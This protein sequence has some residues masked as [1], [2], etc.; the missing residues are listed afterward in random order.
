MCHHL[1]HLAERRELPCLGFSLALEGFHP[2]FGS[3]DYL[4]HPKSSSQ[5]HNAWVLDQLHHPRSVED[6]LHHPRSV[7]HVHHHRARQPLRQSDKRKRNCSCQCSYHDQ[8]N[9]F[10][11]RN[12]QHNDINYYHPVLA[13][14]NDHPFLAVANKALQYLLLAHHN[15]LR[16]RARLGQGSFR[17]ADQHLLLRRLVC[18]HRHR[19]LGACTSDEH[20]L[21]EEQN[22]LLGLLVQY[23]SI[24]ASMGCRVQRRKVLSQSMD[25]EGRC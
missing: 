1:G 18:V 21:V 17:Q 6:Q 8:Y 7:E 16:W 13:V 25:I 15:E 11:P 4:H 23:S 9:L 5:L 20:R 19:R 2:R 24:P 10:D 3:L 14:A 12:N 22:V